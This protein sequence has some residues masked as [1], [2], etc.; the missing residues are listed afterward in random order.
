MDISDGQDTTT[1]ARSVG[2]GAQIPA[3]MATNRRGLDCSV[4]GPAPSSIPMSPM[5]EIRLN[6]MRSRHNMSTSQR[7]E[8]AVAIFIVSGEP[9]TVTGVMK[10][11]YHDLKDGNKDATIEFQETPQYIRVETP[12]E[13]D[14]LALIRTSQRLAA[15][16]LSGHSTSTKVIFVEPPTT[17]KTSNFQISMDVISATKR[18]R[19][20]LQKL[21]GTQD[22]AL[23]LSSSRYKQE[24]SKGLCEVFEMACLRSSLILKI[25]LGYYLLET[26]KTGKFTLE[27][28]ESMVRHPRAT[29]QLDTRL[30]KELAGNLSIEAIMRL[31]QAPDSPCIPVDNQTSTSADVTPTYVLESWHDRD[32]YETELEIIKKPS[33]IDEPLR[34]NLARTKMVP[35]S[36]QV[37]RFEAISISIGRILDWKIA[38]MP[39]ND[40]K[41]ASLAVKQYLKKGKAELQGSRDD[42]HSYPAIRLPEN[43]PIATKLKSVTIKSIYRFSWKGSGYIVQFTINRCWESIREMNTKAPMNT[44]FDVTIYADGWDQDSRVQAGETVGKIWGDDLQGLLRDEA[45]DATGCALSRVRGLIETILDIRDFLESA[46]PV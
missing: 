34:F 19:A 13:E 16:H 39:G 40:K 11:I 29:G 4:G 32:R 27:Q 7:P 42:F 41:R 36:A 25:H 45:G 31:I 10:A 17:C 22:L 18:A 46:S 24:F 5:A 33:R 1:L 15:N 8:N 9:A 23:G 38:V 2:D 28:F 3:N 21:P 30:G 14:A 6:A 12:T 43:S 26:Y 44:D 20:V 35:Q 37:A